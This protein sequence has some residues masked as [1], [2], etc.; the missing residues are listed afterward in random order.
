[1][2]LATRRAFLGLLAASGI[3]AAACHTPSAVQ[4]NGRRVVVLGA[5]LAGLSAAYNLVRSG[6]EIVVLEAQNRPGGRVQTVRAPFVNG[7][8][9]EIGAL[10]IP[11]VHVYTNKHRPAIYDT[12]ERSRVAACADVARR[13][14][15]Q[16]VPACR[17]RTSVLPNQNRVLARRSARRSG[18]AQDDRYRHPR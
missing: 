9:A 4:R 5:S 2:T 12:K 7:G 13:A 6:F 14:S 15:H 17:R 1:M 8:Y 3:A 16:S 10:R 18:R 11:D